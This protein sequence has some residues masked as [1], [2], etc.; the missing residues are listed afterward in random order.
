MRAAGPVGV[1]CAA[2]GA[3]D[4]AR[5]DGGHRLAAGRLTAAGAGHRTRSVCSSP[6]MRASANALPRRRRRDALATQHEARAEKL[7]N[8]NKL[9]EMN[10]SKLKAEAQRESAD[11]KRCL[12]LTAKRVDEA[13]QLA[14]HAQA[15]SQAAQTKFASPGQGYPEVP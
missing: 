3:A 7:A 14:S 5:G 8:Q 10:I 13:K 9:L 11:V 15:L 2:C 6:R 1:A 12:Q 4:D